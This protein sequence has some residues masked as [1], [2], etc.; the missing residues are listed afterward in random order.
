MKRIVGFLMI[1]LIAAGIARAEIQVQSIEYKEGE[2]VL[3]GYIAYDDAQPGKRPGILVV[4]QWM[5][6]GEHEL[7]VIR[8]FAALGYAG[9]AA[10]IYGK[11]VRPANTAEAGELS[12]KY[13]DDRGLYRARLNAGLQTLKA[14]DIVDGGK[15]AAIGYCFG[16]T[17]VL[18]LA[19]SGAELNAVVSFHGGLDTPAPEDAKNIRAAVQVHHGAADP[20]VPMKDVAAFSEE[21][22]NGGVADWQLAMYGNAKHS[23]TEKGAKD[24][25]G[26]PTGYNKEADRRSWA[27]MKRLFE[28]KFK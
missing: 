19:R 16:G 3:K 26:S 23:F 27:A 11:D 5:G 28:E 14:Q 25:E 9:M 6:I 15:T 12:G 13:K 20:L 17:G 1:F 7:D 24:T 8:A 18:E 22:A 21:M 10:D 2:T 4:H